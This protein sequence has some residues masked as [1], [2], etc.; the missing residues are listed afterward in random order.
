[1]RRPVSE[2]EAL[3][4]AAR[5]RLGWLLVAA[6]AA[7]T[8]AALVAVGLAAEVS[9]LS[10]LDSWTNRVWFDAAVSHPTWAAVVRAV[11]FWGNT[12]VVIT[13]TV[14]VVGWQGYR[15]RGR[16]ALWVAATVI[17]G[18][19]VNSVLKT[20]VGRDRPPTVG[21]LLDAKGSSF[22]SG[23]AQVGGYA[24]VTF[25]L[26]ALLVTVGPRRWLTAG[27]CWVL[28]ASIALSRVVLGVHWT[29]DVVAG[30]AVGTGVA[31][32]SASALVLVARR[33]DSVLEG[34]PWDVVAVE[35][36][37]LREE[38]ELG[39]ERDDL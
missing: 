23:H 5:W 3:A 38:R 15:R 29:T 24:W 26:L 13:L 18:W 14:A 17:A 7:A 12:S 1:M 10:D 2:R 34:Q 22:P 9:L 31:L 28:G 32:L 20:L 30:F 35:P 36:E 25:G 4:R 6:V 16:L 8:A 33:T 27:L 37:D 21:L 39:L 19:L 11:T